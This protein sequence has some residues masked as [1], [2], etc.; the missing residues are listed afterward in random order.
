MAKSGQPSVQGG[1]QR[2][3]YSP[4]SSQIIRI[5]HTTAM[6]GHIHYSACELL[7]SIVAD[8]LNA[9]Q[10]SNSG[11]ARISSTSASLIGKKG[12]R[13]NSS[14]ITATGAVTPTTLSFTRAATARAVTMLAMIGG[15]LALTS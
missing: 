12:S 5:S 10:V 1:L 8:L 4:S 13:L 2:P 6:V 9:N 7:G 15:A 11:T 14:D 3:A